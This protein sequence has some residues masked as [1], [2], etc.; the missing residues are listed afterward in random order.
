MD[1]NDFARYKYGIIIGCIFFSLLI[2]LI[3]L[4]FYRND[5][6][7]V[8]GITI[9]TVTLCVNFLLLELVVKVMTRN[10]KVTMGICLQVARF[11]I[12]GITA[13]IAYKISTVAVVGYAFSVLGLPIS[14]SII[15]LRK[16]GADGKL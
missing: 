12:F 11:L 4:L 3:S 10:N 13:Y 8:E 14:S 5:L 6:S 2:A 9:G 16:E 7:L 15:F 1:N